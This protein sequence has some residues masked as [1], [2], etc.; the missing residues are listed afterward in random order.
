MIAERIYESIQ[1][2]RF[3]STEEYSVDWLG[4]NPS[5]YR[6]IKSRKIQPSDHALSNLA[7]RLEKEAE[8]FRK[9]LHPSIQELADIFDVLA[10]D[11]A[12]HL[13]GKNER[14]LHSKWVRAVIM[15]SISEID[16]ARL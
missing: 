9:D 4:M 10:K 13:L 15:K 5:Y 12:R 16:S 11:V 1:K 3:M 2:I 6:T 14:I 7:A 8:L